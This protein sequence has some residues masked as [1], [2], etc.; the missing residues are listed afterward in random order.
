MSLFL[1]SDILTFLTDQEIGDDG[2]VAL[3]EAICKCSS[4]EHIDLSRNYAPLVLSFVITKYP[5][6]DIRTEG[7]AKLASVLPIFGSLH[8]LNLSSITPLFPFHFFHFL[9]SNR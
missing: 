5:G 3:V 7:V 4:L 2:T 8:Y 1:S 6:N 9:P